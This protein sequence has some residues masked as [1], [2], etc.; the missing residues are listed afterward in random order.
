MFLSAMSR[1]SL[2]DHH[3]YHHRWARVRFISPTVKAGRAAANWPAPRASTN[4][5]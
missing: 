3:H 4:A 2:R 5:G 1:E